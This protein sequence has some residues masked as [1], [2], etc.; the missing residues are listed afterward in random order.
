MSS[1]EDIIAG[2]VFVI[3]AVA[4]PA[5]V[6]AH[7]FFAIDIMA[8]ADLGVSRY[9]F[10]WSF[11]LLAGAVTAM[12]AYLSYIRPWMHVRKHGSL[13][14]YSHVSGLPAIGGFLVLF[15]GALIPAS[16]VVGFLLLGVYFADV[17]GL[18]WFLAVTA[19][20]R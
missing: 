12:N 13:D 11:A 19:L 17:G 3:T 2:T 10:G 9:L 7:H 14:D 8:F 15:A 16:P 4:I 1:R 5:E 18:P 6:A 20:Q